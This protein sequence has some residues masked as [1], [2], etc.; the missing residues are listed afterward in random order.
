MTGSLEE[1]TVVLPEG[2]LRML[3]EPMLLGKPSTASILTFLICHPD[4]AVTA[5]NGERI[6]YSITVAVRT[7]VLTAFD[8]IL[9]TWEDRSE[10]LLALVH[11]EDEARDERPQSSSLGADD[12][13]RCSHGRP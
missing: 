3:H 12:G 1:I 8:S 13:H 7:D 9:E 11:L 2:P 10:Q 4:T 5:N 6:M